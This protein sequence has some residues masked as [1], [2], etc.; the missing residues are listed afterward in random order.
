MVKKPAVSALSAGKI[1]YGL[2]VPVGG[3]EEVGSVDVGASE[4]GGADVGA[5]SSLPG[6][7]PL[8]LP[9]VAVAPAAMGTGAPPP[10][11][12]SPPPA[13]PITITPAATAMVS[14]LLTVTVSAGGDVD[15]GGAEPVRVIG[16]VDN[17]VGGEDGTRD[18]LA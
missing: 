15:E 18:P 13:P 16:R 10:T 12:K 9:A 17:A 1:M 4:L 2:G 5:G 3:W 11:V 8:W 14:P 7:S 6:S